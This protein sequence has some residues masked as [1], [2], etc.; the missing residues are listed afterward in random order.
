MSKVTKLVIRGAGIQTL[1]CLALMSRLVPQQSRG[2]SSFKW[3]VDGVDMD[4]AN[5][6]LGEQ[7]DIKSSRMKSLL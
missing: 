5:A 7:S 4:L 2:S 1:V 6:N 3:G